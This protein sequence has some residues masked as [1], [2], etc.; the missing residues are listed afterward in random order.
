MAQFASRLQPLDPSDFSYPV[1]DATGLKG[2]WDFRL[3]FT[4]TFV[5][6]N[7]MR[8]S[9]D[10]RASEPTGGISIQDAMMK[11]LGL[12]LEQRKRVLPVVEIDHIEERPIGN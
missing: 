11:Q 2:S 4:P 1:Q 9:G 10:G 3:S 8:E 5:L 12:K 6:K 7:P